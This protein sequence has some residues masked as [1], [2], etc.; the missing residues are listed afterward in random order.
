M[1]DG[2]DK[3]LA[4]LKAQMQAEEAAGLR[5]RKGKNNVVPLRPVPDLIER[6]DEWPTEA[7]V[8]RVTT[9][10]GDHDTVRA[11]NIA[12]READFVLVK[13]TGLTLGAVR[14]L[15]EPHRDRLLAEVEAVAS[16]MA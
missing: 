13:A 6:H 3:T 7:E 8:P 1:R 4:E 11:R 15:G 16:V 14:R 10:G 12:R 2:N 9:G 5:P